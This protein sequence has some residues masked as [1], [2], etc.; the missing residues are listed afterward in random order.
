MLDLQNWIYHDLTRN[1]SLNDQL[2]SP[3]VPYWC[4]DRWMKPYNLPWSAI[5]LA[6]TNI[7][8][9][10]LHQLKSKPS[11]IITHTWPPC[12]STMLHG[13][14]TQVGRRVHHKFVYLSLPKSTFCNVWKLLSPPLFLPIKGCTPTPPCGLVIISTTKGIIPRASWVKYPL[15]AGAGCVLTVTFTMPALPDKVTWIFLFLLLHYV[16]FIGQKA[17]ILGNALG[18]F[19]LLYSILPGCFHLF[20]RDVCQRVD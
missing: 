1:C 12:T 15:I 5:F 17:C 14:H 16:V 11:N 19:V 2:G 3:L 18:L 10:M 6:K 20:N 8:W 4:V 9:I 13:L 7:K